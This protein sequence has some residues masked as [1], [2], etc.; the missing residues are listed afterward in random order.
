MRQTLPR[1]VLPNANSYKHIITKEWLFLSSSEILI[2]IV[3][4]SDHGVIL[5]LKSY[6]SFE[7]KGNCRD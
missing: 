4:G 3:V 5:F 2:S 7:I 1:A 6:N